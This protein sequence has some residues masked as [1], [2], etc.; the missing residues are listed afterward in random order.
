MRLGLCYNLK[1][2]SKDP[3]PWDDSQAEYEDAE[4]VE[5]LAAALEEIAGRPP[6]RLP[7]DPHLPRRLQEARLD[8][9]FNIAEGWGGRNREAFAPTLLEMAGIPYTGS[10][11]LTLSLSLDKALT[12]KVLASDGL[13]TPRFVLLNDPAESRHVDLDFPLLVKP[14]HEGTSKGIRDF[15]RVESRAE[16]ERVAAWVI[17]RYGQPALVEPYLC[18][19]EFAV[20]LL[21]NGTD[22]QVLPHAAIRFSRERP[23]YSFECKTLVDEEVV[24]PA[25]LEPEVEEKLRRLGRAAFQALGCRDLARLDLRLDREGRPWILEIN[26]LPGLSPRYS[27]FPIQAAAAGLDYTAMVRAVV[28]AAMQRTTGT[29]PSRS[30][31]QAWQEQIRDRLRDP[32]EL[33]RRLRL[34]PVT[35]ERLAARPRELAFSITPYLLSVMDADDPACPVRR[36]FVP[37]AAELSDS[38]G[39]EDPLRESEHQIADGLIQVY[40]DRAA[41]CVSTFCPSLCRHCLRRN[42]FQA[43]RAPQGLPPGLDGVLRTLAGRPGITDLLITGGEPLALEDDLLE[44]LLRRIREV[45]SVRL[46]RIGTRL[47]CT[48]PQRITPS[49]VRLLRAHAPIWISTQFNHPKEITPQAAEVCVRLADGGIPVLNQSVLLHGINDRLAVLKELGERLVR[50]RVRP[51]YLYQCQLVRGTAHFRTPVERGVALLRGLRGRTTGFA[52]P[53]LVLDT[54]YGKVPLSPSYLQG[55]ENG[56]VVVESFDG[57]IWREPNPQEEGADAGS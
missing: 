22:L 34:D 42:R 14:C 6:V 16:L 43:A 31:R 17:G 28:Q 36:Q 41:W 10:D 35:Q 39:R 45:D 21:G 29:A 4:T 47:P 25:D 18:G 46:L 48:L 20:A 7:C 33:A 38:L 44:E 24:C 26:P 40:P 56:S 52:I 3:D 8:L 55:R 13:P 32:R 9:V 11:G 2:A 53:L 30:R 27:L 5:A 51:Y 19:P 57:R 54:P 12:K 49:L 50:I 15:S 37:S 1:Q 23:F